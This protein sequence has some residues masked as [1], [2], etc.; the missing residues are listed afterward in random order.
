MV[1]EQLPADGATSFEQVR[2]NRHLLHAELPR[3]FCRRHSQK[4]YHLE[5]LSLLRRKAVE[6]L[7]DE[8]SEPRAVQVA[9]ACLSNR[10]RGR[11]P[12]LE[13]K[14]APL[15]TPSL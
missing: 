15:L 2:A 1:L 13:K 4:V 5:N 14:R 11:N 8:R 9:L 6:V 3:D 7:E 12:T 10:R